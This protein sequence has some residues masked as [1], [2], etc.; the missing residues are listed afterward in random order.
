MTTA[1]YMDMTRAIAVELIEHS[2][3]E[4]EEWR[5]RACLANSDLR[6]TLDELQRVTDELEAV[7]AP[8]RKHRSRRARP[9]GSRPVRV[10][11]VL[12]PYRRG[13]PEAASGD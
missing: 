13:N 4:P 8:Y 9:V 7:L 12:V 6:L 2:S 1:A 10:M 11:N 3:A 5:E